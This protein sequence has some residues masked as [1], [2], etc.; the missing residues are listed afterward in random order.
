MLIKF[1]QTRTKV[2]FIIEGPYEYKNMIDGSISIVET[3]HK[4]GK[5][6]LVESSIDEN[7][8][9]DLIS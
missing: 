9:N 6:I 5:C 7:V 1:D 4:K 2:L 3:K 8:L